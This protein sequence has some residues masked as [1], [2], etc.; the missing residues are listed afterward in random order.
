MRPLEWFLLLSFNPILLLPL[1]DLPMRTG[2]SNGLF[3][4]CDVSV[5]LL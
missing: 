2:M 1:L 3:P 4:V 5:T